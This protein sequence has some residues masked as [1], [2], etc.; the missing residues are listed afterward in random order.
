MPTITPGYDFGPTETPRRTTLLQQ[1][2]G[3]QVTG[4]PVSSIDTAVLKVSIQDATNATNLP[5]EGSLWVDAQGNIWGRTVDGDVKVRR[6]PG[7]WETNRFKSFGDVG[8]NVY[9]APGIPIHIVTASANSTSLES[10]RMARSRQAGDTGVHL[11]AFVSATTTYSNHSPN[12][13][14]I[15]RG[16]T[17]LFCQ[18]FLPG[19]PAPRLRGY[20]NPSFASYWIAQDLETTSPNGL[21]LESDEK[22][23]ECPSAISECRGYFMGLTIRKV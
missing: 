1:A 2:T 22:E 12:L 16:P 8:G 3:L 4:I 19:S 10:T 20:N 13:R 21:Q 7:G 6:Y 9:E 18:G 5:A 14:Y 17:R 11:Q 15:G 23:P